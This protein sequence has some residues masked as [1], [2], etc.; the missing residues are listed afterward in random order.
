MR[1]ECRLSA[2]AAA[3][4]IASLLAATASAQSPTEAAFAAETKKLEVIVVTG[5]P[6]KDADV[7]A[8]VSVLAGPELVLKRGTTLGDTLSGMPGVSNSSFGPN[9]GRPSIRGLDGDRIRFLNNSGASFDAS[10]VSFDHNPSIDPLVIERVEVLRGPAALLYGGTAIG[11][12]VNVI[13]NRIPRESIKGFGGTTEARA[14]GSSQERGYS[15]LLEGGNGQFA[16]HAD[17]FRR[18]TGD[19]RVP[20][21]AGLGNRIANS[22]SDSQGGAIGGSLTFD[23]GYAGISRSDYR[24]VYGTVADAAVTINMKQT[25]TTFDSEF[26]N[27]GSFVESVSIRG[28]RTDY[29]HVEFEG[30]IAGTVFTNQGSDYRVELRHARLGNAGTSSS[31][32]MSRMVIRRNSS[33]V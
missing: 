11:G 31:G 27:L 17:G 16:L 2:A 6:L 19:Y 7:V 28:G 30:A 8:P 29:R 24:T 33:C 4:Y 12:V 20:T 21:S 22:A 1:H 3:L 15:M 23:G 10:N 9:A 32:R 25:R 13:D 26:G 18:T 14:G 5:N